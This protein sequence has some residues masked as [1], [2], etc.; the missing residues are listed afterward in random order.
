MITL[1]DLRRIVSAKYKASTERII[2]QYKT[3]EGDA[4]NRY[5]EDIQRGP[6]PFLFEEC[7]KLLEFACEKEA[8]SLPDHEL[9]L[10][11]FESDHCLNFD[12]RKKANRGDWI[13]GVS[14]EL[15]SRV[16]EIASN[17]DLEEIEDEEL[18]ELTA[19]ELAFLQRVIELLQSQLQR[20]NLTAESHRS[21]TRAIKGLQALPQPTEDL[22]VLCT[23]Q[24]PGAGGS[25]FQSVLI[26]SDS[27][28]FDSRGSCYSSDIGSDSFGGESFAWYAGGVR[29]GKGEPESWLMA[30]DDMIAMGASIKIEDEFAD[31]D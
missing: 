10:L 5:V 14:E 15:F 13:H 11:W 8:R 30:A 6:S 25:S 28:E 12:D 19:R 3:F 18:F 27:L 29:D 2:V 23:I 7:V 21:L 17:E 9:E 20:P 26:S 1:R 4:W 22:H 16:T 24:Q 31:E